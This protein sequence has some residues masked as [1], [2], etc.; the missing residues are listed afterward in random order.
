MK[1]QIKNLNQTAKKQRGVVAVEYVAVAAFTV[2][3][4]A[5]ILDSSG[6]IV[7]GLNTAITTFMALLP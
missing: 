6:T 2:T 4:L 3:F 1:K 7:T 5:A